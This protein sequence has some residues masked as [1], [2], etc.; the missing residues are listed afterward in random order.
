[1]I[2]VIER[3]DKSFEEIKD[4][5]EENCKHLFLAYIVRFDDEIEEFTAA[6]VSHTL[7]KGIKGET[8]T[9]R[10]KSEYKVFIK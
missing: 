10:F 9:K 1:M 7:A 6:L 4:T 8:L 2:S 3:L 5:I